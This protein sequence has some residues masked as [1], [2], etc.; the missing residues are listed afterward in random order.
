MDCDPNNISLDETLN[1]YHTIARSHNIV[2]NNGINIL[3]LNGRSIRNKFDEIEIIIDSYDKIIHLLIIV[4]TWL[5]ENEK[6]FYNLNEYKAYHSTR[7][8]PG[9]GVSIFCHVSIESS[10]ILEEN[11]LTVANCVIIKL[12]KLNI[13]VAA[14]YK[15]PDCDANEFTN[16]FS[17]YMNKF[18]NIFFFG[19]YNINISNNTNDSNFFKNTVNSDG[20]VILNNTASEY[21]TR[22][23]S[24]SATTI[25]LIIT[26]LI[27]YNFKLDVEDICISDH[28]LLTLNL[29]EEPRQ[30]ENVL[31]FKKLNYEKF[32]SDLSEQLDRHCPDNFKE[33]IQNISNIKERNTISIRKIVKDKKYIND[34]TSDELKGAMKQRKVYYDLHKT[35]SENE[36]YKNKYKE[37]QKLTTDIIKKCKQEFYTK[38]FEKSLGSSRKTWLNINELIYNKKK[39]SNSLLPTRIV[40]DGNTYVDG[41]EICDI[42]NEYFGDIAK[43]IGLDNNN[44]NLDLGSED[45]PNEVLNAFEPTNDEEILSIIT[46]LNSNSASG[47]DSISAGLVKKVAEQLSPIIV[48]IINECL[49]NGIFPDELKIARVTVIHKS[50]RKDDPNNYRAISVLPIFSKIFETV[51]NSRIIEYL[52]KV[53]FINPNQFGFQRGSNT[54][55]AAIHLIEGIYRNIDRKLKTACTFIDVR[56]AFDSVDHN[57]LL[58]KLYK[59]GFRD[60]A[61]S[62]MNSYL[63]SRK[64]YISMQNIV[65]SE[66]IMVRGV[67]QGSILGAILFIIFVNDIFDQIWHGELQLYAD[68]ASIIYGAKNFVELNEKMLSDIKTLDD[69]MKQNKLVVNFNKTNFMIFELKK[70]NLSQNFNE[71]CY[72]EFL[73]RRVDSAKYLGLYLDTSL[74]FSYHID[75]MKNKISKFVGVFRRISNFLSESL[76]ITIYYAHIHSHIIY[77]NSIWSGAPE[78][79]LKELQILQNK[80]IK[81]IYRLPHLTSS[82]SL[83][84]DKFLPIN[85]ISKY[86]KCLLLFKLK[87]N[88]LKNDFQFLRNE[89]VHSH[90]TRIARNIRSTIFRT[91]RAQ[92]S[93]FSSATI[94]FNSLPEA[95]KFEQEIVVFKKNIK[96]YFTE[97][98]NLTGSFR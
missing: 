29:N 68:D 5:R 67:P 6:S 10:I 18:K 45:A 89:E 95:I 3:Y 34:W 47:Y 40:H 58:K 33:L 90:F 37:L 97:L 74:S 70:S 54:S 92:N 96:L 20:F 48:R 50:G 71:I 52:D 77:L 46:N 81:I 78:Y 93:I 1:I 31:T 61:F 62:T 28:R 17:G 55:A 23:T 80:A 83:Y 69:W 15:P 65:S 2:S 22:L 79:K 13:N 84:G 39:D 42:L 27:N 85:I 30:T 38:K 7:D 36:F 60:K 25:D 32:K 76:K 44:Y 14:I 59:I 43:I 24:Q 87:N 16:Y 88:L 51:L 82:I 86:E 21:S 41:I 8:K 4:E 53:E 94:E 98:F 57:L 35:F 73:I 19:D 72:K 26:D 66:K 49:S 9:G 11:F 12:N 75:Q 56:K 64:Q 63:T 91:K